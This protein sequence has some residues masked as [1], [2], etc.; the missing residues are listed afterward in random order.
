MTKELELTPEE[1]DAVRIGTGYSPT[2]PISQ[3]IKDIKAGADAQLQKIKDRGDIFV[4]VKT[5]LG[6]FGGECYMYEFI[7]L[8]EEK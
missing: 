8:S 7:P 3:N 6:T 2:K 1:I 4:K 5:K